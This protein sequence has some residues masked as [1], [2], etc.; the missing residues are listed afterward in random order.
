M[1]QPLRIVKRSNQ[2]PRLYSKSDGA[3][4]HPP[5][6]RTSSDSVSNTPVESFRH[7]RSSSIISLCTTPPPS[8]EAESPSLDGCPYEEVILRYQPGD[9]RPSSPLANYSV[10]PLRPSRSRQPQSYGPASHANSHSPT[11]HQTRSFSNVPQRVPQRQSNQY[12]PHPATF[13]PLV[14]YSRSLPGSEGM[15]TKVDAAAFYNP[16][17]SAHLP[18]RSL[19]SPVATSDREN[20]VYPQDFPTMA[21]P[22][23]YN[24]LYN[25]PGNHRSRLPSAP[26]LIHSTVSQPL[27]YSQQAF[28]QNHPDTRWHNYQQ[29][30]QPSR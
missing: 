4:G 21:Q 9:S 23:T 24:P 20:G 28:P 26:E 8:F 6:S 7:S 27:Y 1:V 2:L 14:A 17:V 15:P 29:P 22:Q 13:D 25:Y 5:Y 10:A 11:S 12:R 19:Q 3:S 30:L 18:S 16:A